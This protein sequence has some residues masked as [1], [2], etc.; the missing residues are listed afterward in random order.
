M[1]GIPNFLSSL[2]LG[3]VPVLLMLAFASQAQLF[4]SCLVISLLTDAID[5]FI[6]RRFNATSE[7]GAKLDSWADCATYLALPFCAW[8]LRP[9]VIRAEALVIATV[10]VFY[11][12]PILI[13][14]LKYER[15]TSYHT[16]LAKVCAVAAAVVMLV[17]FS[18]GPGWAWRAFAPLLVISGLE[19]IAITVLLAEWRA[20]VPT[21]WHALRFKR[22]AA[23]VNPADAGR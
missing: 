4:L 5:G 18:G 3:F 15:L 19:E 1:A 16:W 6:A 22:N 9:Q 12:A 11:V 10:V 7:L 20:N 21:L 2:R 8:W 17:F 13:G 23:A 14:F